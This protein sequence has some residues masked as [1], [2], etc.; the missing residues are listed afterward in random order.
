MDSSFIQEKTIDAARE[1]AGKLNREIAKGND[2]QAFMLAMILASFKDFLDII[3]TFTLIGLIPGV[4]FTLGLFLTSF[5]F[6]FMLGKGWF[7]K[8][9]IKIWFWVLGLL[10]DG[11]PAFSVLPMNT[12]LVAYAWRLAKKRGVTAQEK[13]HN[14]ENLSTREVQR[15]NEDISLLEERRSILGYIV[16][17][18]E[19]ATRNKTKHRKAA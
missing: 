19:P 14:L 13:L 17:H 3:L 18:T 8:L 15:L 5:L 1:L 11:L 10:V 2:T 9:R 6:F 16:G 12:L 7:L 4:N